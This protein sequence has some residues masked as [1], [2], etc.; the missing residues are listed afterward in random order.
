MRYREL[1]RTEIKV[2]EIGIGGEGF[3]NKS[4]F[5]CKK[6]IDCAITNGINLIDIYNSNPDVRTNVG[7]ALSRYPRD[8]FVIQGHLCSMWENGQYRRTRNMKEVVAA[9][10]DLLTRMQLEYVDI[11]MIHYMDDER[12]FGSILR[13]VYGKLPIRCGCGQ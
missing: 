10:E 7:K 8:S 12:D 4:Y 13:T 2:S 11:G 3:E 9:Y 6:I 5:D 1:G